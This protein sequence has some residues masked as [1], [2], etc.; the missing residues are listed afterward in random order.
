MPFEQWLGSGN[1]RGISVEQMSIEVTQGLLFFLFRVASGFIPPGDVI[2]ED[3]ERQPCSC[4]PGHCPP[5]DLEALGPVM[6]FEY[7]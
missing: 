6:D 2:A 7:A 4:S 3:L 1:A 5:K